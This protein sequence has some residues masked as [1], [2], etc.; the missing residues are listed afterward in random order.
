LLQKKK[1]DEESPVSTPNKRTAS[2]N[3]KMNAIKLKQSD[4]ERDAVMDNE[5]DEEDDE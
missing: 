1:V 2:I 5:E 3:R 4:D